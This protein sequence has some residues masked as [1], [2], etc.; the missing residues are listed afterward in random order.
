M[1]ATDGVAE[2][3]TPGSHASTFGGTPLVTAVALRTLEI[4]SQPVFLRRVQRI[5]AYLYTCLQQLRERYALIRDVRGRG[6]LLGMELTIPGQ[7]IVNRCLKAG[8]VINCVQ[9]N[10][11]RFV[12]PLTIETDEVDRLIQVLN[13][14]L[15]EKAA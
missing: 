8:I 10:V 13:E 12:P 1:L 14:V 9:E 15:R 6:L 11:L 4:I 5:G 2:A 7:D 3:F